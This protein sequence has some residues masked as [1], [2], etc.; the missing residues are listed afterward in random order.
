MQT[1][2]SV[3]SSIGTDIQFVDKSCLQADLASLKDQVAHHQT[4]LSA[5]QGEVHK[6]SLLCPIPPPPPSRPL[7]PTNVLLSMG[8]RPPSKLHA[9]ADALIWNDA[10]MQ[11]L[12]ACDIMHHLDKCLKTP[13][14]K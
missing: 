14:D 8:E 7:L 12:H 6:V 2:F 9:L 11:V 1:H 13:V 5:L 3:V 4:L 10:L